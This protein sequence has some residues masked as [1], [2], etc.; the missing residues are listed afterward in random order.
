MKNYYFQI[1][2]VGLNF[3]LGHGTFHAMGGAVMTPPT[4]ER[5]AKLSRFSHPS[6]VNLSGDYGIPLKPFIRTRGK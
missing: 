1:H 6:Q 5:P 3:T 2:G 4:S